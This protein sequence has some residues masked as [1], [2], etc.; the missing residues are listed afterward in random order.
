MTRERERETACKGTNRTPGSV[1][2]EIASGLAG[3]LLF[4]VW[5]FG[6]WLGKLVRALWRKISLAGPML[7]HLFGMDSPGLNAL[8]RP[9]SNVPFW[10]SFIPP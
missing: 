8:A 4:A 10:V 6:Q 9:S 5:T 1:N 3:G 7:N 2:A